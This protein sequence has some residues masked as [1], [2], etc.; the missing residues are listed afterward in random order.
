[1]INIEDQCKQIFYETK[2]MPSYAVVI[3][4]GSLERIKFPQDNVTLWTEEQYINLSK[5]FFTKFIHVFKIAKNLCD[6]LHTDD[7][8]KT[9]TNS[10]IVK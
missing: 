6:P 8:N 1:M 9:S 3:M 10:H 4:V 5:T 7:K 2:W